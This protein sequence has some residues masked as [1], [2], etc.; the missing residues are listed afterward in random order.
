[1][2]ER[3]AE[4]REAEGRGAPLRQ[5]RVGCWRILLLPLAERL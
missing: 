5:D 4:E 2:R 3:A 1:M